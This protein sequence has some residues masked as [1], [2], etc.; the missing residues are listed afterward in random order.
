M[1]NLKFLIVDNV[2]ICKPLEFLPNKLILLKWTHYPF[3]WPSEYFPE[4]LVAIEMPHSRIRLPNLIK[5][6]CHLENLIDLNLRDCKFITELPKLQALNLKYL[7]ISYCENLVEIDECF[8]SLEKL[9]GWYL[10]DCGN[11]QV[12]PSQLRLKSLD[13]LNLS[14]CSGLE[15]LPNFHPEME[16]LETS[17]LSGSGIREVP[18]SIEHLTKLAELSLIDCKNLRELPDS[19]YKLQQLQIL[20]TP[21]AKLRPMCNSFDGSSGYGFVNMTELDFRGY[22]AIIELDLLMKPDYFPALEVINLS[23][24]NIVTIPESISR[25][26]RLIDLFITNCKL[27]REIRGLPQSIRLVE[28][29]NCML[30]DT[31]SPIGL[32]NQVIEIIGILPSRVCG[33]ARSNKL[34]DPQLTNYF[35]SETEGA[36]SEDQ[37][38][39]MD[40]QFS[41]NF[42]PETEGVEYEYRDVDYTIHFWGTEIPKWF[43]HQNDDNS[44]FF[45]VGRKFPKLVVCIFGRISGHIDISI[46]GYTQCKYKYID[47]IGNN[48]CLFS[49]TQQSLQRHLNKSNPTDQNLVEVS[50]TDEFNDICYCLKRWGVH[51][52]CTCPPQESANAPIWYSIKRLGVQVDDVVEYLPT[53]KKQRTF[54]EL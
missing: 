28:A 38:I 20:D 19:I 2:H 53:S 51:V 46:N 26:S 9:K 11:L 32:L 24:T 41:N 54:D 22:K 6:G 49:P 13:F 21:T 25:F 30:L 36:E 29:K 17:Y 43:N 52:E 7:D 5:Q 8:G 27:L 15:K 23:D 47:Q 39:S 37:D 50:I 1:E 45:F 14:G 4:Q 3:H 40:S 42:P 35:P 12:L 31:Q 18:S 44:I 16:C 10:V 34:M 33:R 48:L